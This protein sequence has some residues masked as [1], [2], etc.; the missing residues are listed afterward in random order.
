[1]SFIKDVTSD[2]RLSFTVSCNSAMSIKDP[3]VNSSAVGVKLLPT[4][5]VDLYAVHHKCIR[6][7]RGQSKLLASCYGTF[8]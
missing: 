4:I 7:P 6:Q 2:Q 8:L 3:A 1:M 5:D